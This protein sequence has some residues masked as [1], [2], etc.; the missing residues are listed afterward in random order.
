MAQFRGWIKG[1]RGQASRLGSKNSGLA[2]N[3]ASWQGSVTVSLWTTDDGVDMARV[4]LAP[5]TNGAGEYR[6]LYDG[7]VSG[8]GAK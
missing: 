8:K 7:P 6:L 5:H 1:Q 4:E 3:L 2:A